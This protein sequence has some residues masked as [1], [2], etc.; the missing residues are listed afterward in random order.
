MDLEMENFYGDDTGNDDEDAESNDEDLME[1]DGSDMEDVESDMKDDED[2]KSN[3]MEVVHDGEDILMNSYMEDSNAS[4][5]D[6]D[7]VV[8]IYEF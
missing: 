7:V 2:V 8:D 5:L 4:R 6:V 3:T 1:D